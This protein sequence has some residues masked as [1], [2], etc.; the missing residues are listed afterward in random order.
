MHR[1]K[2]SSLPSL[3]RISIICNILGLAPTRNSTWKFKT[4]AM[5]LLLLNVIGSIYSCLGKLEPEF[6][7]YNMVIK[8]VD[9]AASLFLS[10]AVTTTVVLVVMVYPQ[11]IHGI[12]DSLLEF[13]EGLALDRSCGRLKKIFWISAM[14]TLMMVPTI[15]VLDSWVWLEN[16]ELKLYKYYIVR[17]VQYCQI[18]A[19]MMLWFWTGMEIFQRFSV[20][21]AHLMDNFGGDLLGCGR[22]SLISSENAVEV[23]FENIRDSL[24]KITKYHNFLCEMVDEVNELFGIIILLHVL[25]FTA[26]TVQ[27]TLVLIFY[28]VLGGSIDG[29]QFGGMLRFVSLAW[30]T[31]SEKTSPFCKMAPTKEVDQEQIN[32]EQP[33]AEE[34]QIDR[35]HENVATGKE[36]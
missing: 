31:V 6:D 15:V 4:Y 27:Y 8:I 3:D 5:V 2:K 34:T 33:Q 35:E 22:F 13:D 12:R 19:V 16:V 14:I 1:E 28:T 7:T 18:T 21:N 30:I 24:R 9:Q 10:L 36:Q 17:N 23:S 25:F 11:K 26:Y 20:L 29:Q 32:Q